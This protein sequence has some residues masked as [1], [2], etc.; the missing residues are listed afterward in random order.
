MSDVKASAVY[1]HSSF[2]FCAMIA[3]LS[4]PIIG[5][6]ALL[7]R[8]LRPSSA[9]AFPA[10]HDGNAPIATK[11]HCTYLRARRGLAAFIFS[12]VEKL[13]HP[14]DVL[15]EESGHVSV[16]SANLGIAQQVANGWLR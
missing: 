1:R 7:A 11:D 8:R 10:I 14:I 12:P 6:A 9:L 2:S 3:S 16:L 15:L 5:E 13:I 4:H